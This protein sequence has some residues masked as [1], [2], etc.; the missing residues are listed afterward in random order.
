MSPLNIQNGP[1]VVGTLS[2]PQALASLDAPPC[3]LLEIRFDLIGLP[4]PQLLATESLWQSPCPFIFTPRWQGEGGKLAD[5]GR[6]P[7]YEA[8][9]DRVA[10]VDVEYRCE[11]R[12][13][14]APLAR[15]HGVVPI[16]S[17]HDFET[18]PSLA[19]MVAVVEEAAAL[20][21]VAKIAATANTPEDLQR[22][23]TLLEGD[24]PV[25]ICVIGMGPLGAATRFDFPLRG[26]CL[27]YGFIDSSAAPG[28]PHCR[29]L[30][31]HLRR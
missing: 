22:L 29:E 24:W 13:A 1:F 6:L 28:Q 7:L 23:E 25:P 27:T 10:A 30:K 14:V 8:V 18:T 31:E 16:L 20:G 9:I 4:M 3:D 26:S 19:D 12:K 21:A 15:E 5:E 17:N 2:S 11:L